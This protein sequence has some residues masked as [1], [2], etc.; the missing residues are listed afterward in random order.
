VES[1]QFSKLPINPIELHLNTD[2]MARR[3]TASHHGDRLLE[4]LNKPHCHQQQ[5]DHDFDAMA[6]LRSFHM[7]SYR[8]GNASS[9]CGSSRTLKSAK[10]AES[11]SSSLQ[12]PIVPKASPAFRK[13]HVVAVPLSAPGRLSK[14]RLS[15]ANLLPSQFVKELSCPTLHSGSTT[16]SSKNNNHRPTDSCSSTSATSVSTKEDDLQELRDES[17]LDNVH[18]RTSPLQSRA[19]SVEN[20]HH[21]RRR[22]VESATAITTSG[23]GNRCNSNIR[24]LPPRRQLGMQP[25]FA[26]DGIMKKPPLPFE[27]NNPIASSPIANSYKSTPMSAQCPIPRRATAT[28]KQSSE[29]RAERRRL[30]RVEPILT[31]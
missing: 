9:F 8:T 2:K 19:N 6:K 17:A 29:P 21:S 23:G 3:I 12:A 11:S 14:C 25:S 30:S 28:K 26:G 16:S 22:L 27:G 10:T 4:T 18:H 1:S 31:H 13:A 15:L 24:N 5:K 20:S 7:E